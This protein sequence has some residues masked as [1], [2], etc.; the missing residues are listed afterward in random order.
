M[1]TILN[2]D[3]RGKT[4][5]DWL[6]SYHSFSFGQ[7]FD[8]ERVGFRTLRVLNDDTV[9]P[10]KGFGMHGHRDMEIVS[11]V[12]SGEMAHKDSLGNG[13]VIRHGE[14]LRMS[15]GSGIQHSE[16]NDSDTKPLHFLQIWILP[17]HSGG[18]PSYQQEP[19]DLAKASEEWV[20]L[21]AP[22]GGL[23]TISQDAIIATTIVR[24]GQSR[25]VEFDPS[26]AG[27]LYVAKGMIRLHGNEL[28]AGDAVQVEEESGLQFTAEF[29]AELIMF[30]LA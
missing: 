9:Q 23:V 6:D 21:A 30:D 29:D 11:Y 5:F 12:L 7:Y 3:D 26:R 15:A 24:T 22:E 14:V 17:D 4:E 27:F 19:F 25:S 13:S 8:P 20:V 1:I 2:G 18:D 10:G 28:R 16:W